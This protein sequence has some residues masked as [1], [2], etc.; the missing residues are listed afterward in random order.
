MAL[1]RPLHFMNCPL[2]PPNQI[3]YYIYNMRKHI[4]FS[5]KPNFPAMFFWDFDYPKIDWQASYKTIIARILERGNEEEWEELCRFYGREKV[6]NA[7]KNEIVFLPDYTINEAEQYFH[8]PKENML[9]YIRKQSKPG[10]WI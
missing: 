4:Q 2:N 3:V 10:H 6:E 1:A 7:I 8:I 5:N 9:C